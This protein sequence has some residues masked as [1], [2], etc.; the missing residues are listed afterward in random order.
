MKQSN[1]HA[2]RG[3]NLEQLI[4]FANQYYANK[5]I[6]LIHKVP[7]EWTVIFK[8]VLKAF[9]KRKSIVDF[10][11]IYKGRPIAFD[12]KETKN[13]TNFP[14]DNI[15]QHQFDYLQRFYMMG[16]IAFY[17]IHFT[18]H[19]KI[20]ILKQEDLYK[21]TKES[22]RK[23]IPFHWFDNIAISVDL[24]RFDYLNSLES[25]GL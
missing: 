12:T 9:P 21:I 3:K 2:N 20:Y 11:G 24:T 1:S 4:E 8:P 13:K 18:E 6:A 7:T 16:G 25:E 10:L 23:S 19:R 15:H 17:L 14:L 5:G 22:S